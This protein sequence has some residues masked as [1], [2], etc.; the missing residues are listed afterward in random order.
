MVK[1]I[2]QY[3]NGTAACWAFANQTGTCADAGGCYC[4]VQPTGAVEHCALED[5]RLCW[6]SDEYALYQKLGKL[7][8]VL[9]ALTLVV[10]MTG[11]GMYIDLSGAKKLARRKWKAPAVGLVGQI[12]VNP[13]FL[14]A[15]I[16]LMGPD[17]LPNQKIA[18]MLIACSPG[19][20][21]SNI[22]SWIA[23]GTLEIS[24]IM[25]VV[26]TAAS[27]FTIPLFMY[28]ASQIF[29]EDRSFAVPIQ[30]IVVS[31]A[32]L[33][34]CLALGAY[35]QTRHAG[36]R[37]GV[38]PWALRLM[39]AAIVLVAVLV[40]IY[41]MDPVTGGYIKHGTAAVYTVVVVMNFAGIALGYTLALLVG[42][43]EV[44]R[45]TI[46]F[47][48]GAQNV[49]VPMAIVAL[50]FAAGS[51]T[52]SQFISFLMVYAVIQALVNW[53]IAIGMRYLLPVPDQPEEIARAGGQVAA[54]AAAAGNGSAEVAV[55]VVQMP[56]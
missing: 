25:T 35:L 46:A 5:G 56:K 14:F 45:R 3:Q 4:E 2:E 20:N 22:L 13:F 39:G 43:P 33:L 28:F 30:N 7:T 29:N 9:A 36:G 47:E 44:Y 18:A 26:S 27:M 31:L 8:T 21:G 23:R 16:S 10:F 37:E 55:E 54:A 15:L 17:L 53:T 6:D 38:R 19:G 32:G 40:V 52:Q 24:V 11:V 1:F 48:V 41:L 42:L 34:G 50:S 51:L 49:T 12:V